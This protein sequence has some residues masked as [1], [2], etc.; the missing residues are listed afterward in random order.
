MTRWTVDGPQRLPIDEPVTR[1]DVNMISGRLNVVGGDGPARV[2]VTRVGRKPLTVGVEGGVLSVRHERKPRWP[3]FMWWWFGRNR[4][5]ADV[6]IAVPRSTIADL[7]VIDGSIVASDL[8]AG[9]EV[10]VTS[11][12]IT[13]LGLDGRV[14]AKLISGPVEA[15][16][17]NGDLTMETISGELTLADRT[18]ARVHGTTVSGAITCDLDNPAGSDIRLSTTSGQIT[19]RIREDSDLSVHLHTTSGRITSAFAGLTVDRSVPWGLKDIRG[20]LGLGTGRL[21]VTSTS[22]S[23]SLLARPVDDEV[24]P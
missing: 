4:Y 5:G 17:V 7:R 11:G 23:V 8:R 1:L 9:A 21:Y 24:G 20:Q 12:R 18:A 6:S 2:E 19:V 16:G 10:S 22:G 14:S 13:L 15:V 3:D